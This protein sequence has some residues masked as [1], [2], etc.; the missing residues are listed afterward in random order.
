MSS[1]AITILPAR[2]CR[3]SK[4]ILAYLDAHRV[5]YTRIDLESTEGLALMEAYRLRSS[6]GILVAGESVN[7]YNLLVRPTCRVNEKNAA[8]VFGLEE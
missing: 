7:P 3:R 1:E 4:A 6:P 2:D 8:R 5:P